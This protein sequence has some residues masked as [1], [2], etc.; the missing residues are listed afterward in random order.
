M[1]ILTLLT[2]KHFL[3]KLLFPAIIKDLIKMIILTFLTG[4]RNNGKNKKT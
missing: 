1:K 4:K 3:Y 2:D